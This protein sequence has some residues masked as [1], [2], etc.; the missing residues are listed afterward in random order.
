MRSFS[1]YI[2]PDPSRG[3]LS[4]LASGASR[5]DIRS[6]N[7]M[8]SGVTSFVAFHA[9]RT[10]DCPWPAPCPIPISA[11]TT[12]GTIPSVSARLYGGPALSFLVRRPMTCTR[13]AVPRPARMGAIRPTTA[14]MRYQFACHASVISAAHRAPT[15]MPTKR[16]ANSPRPRQSPMARRIRSA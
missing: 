2:H 11:T 3:L 6:N 15:A 14:R 4:T 7:A 16:A 13:L 5:V 12:I 1:A 8:S 10:I 9:A